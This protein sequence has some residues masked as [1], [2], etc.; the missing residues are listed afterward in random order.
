MKALSACASFFLTITL[1]AAVSSADPFDAFVGTY[2]PVSRVTA[3]NLNAPSCNRFAFLQL[4]G[5]EVRADRTGFRQTHQL[6]INVPNGYSTIRVVPE[7]RERSE[8]DPTIG[9]YGSSDGDAKQA[10]TVTG[11]FGY[12]KNESLTVSMTKTNATYHLQVLN[13]IKS[14]T[15]V[16]EVSCDDSVDLKK[17]ENTN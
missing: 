16:V 8:L 7:F 17:N 4:T 13:E 2:S 12:D 1:I 11:S 3:R 6:L 15:G 9:T 10:T 14:A 5:F